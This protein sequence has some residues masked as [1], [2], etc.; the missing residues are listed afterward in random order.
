MPRPILA[1]DT[2]SPEVS[3]AVATLGGGIEQRTFPQRRSGA[4]LIAALEAVL[5]A[6]ALERHDLG[7]IVAVRGPGSFTGLRVGLATA[8]GLSQALGIPATAVSTFQALAWGAAEPGTVLALAHA[9][10]EDWFAQRFRERQ[11]D[12]EPVRLPL[13]RLRELGVERWVAA[14]AEGPHADA[15]AAAGVALAAVGPLA[16][17]LA[18]RAVAAPPPWDAAALSAPLYLAPPPVAP[19]SPPKSVLGPAPPDPSRA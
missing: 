10:H 5:A 16:A 17:V 8:L 6:A 1:I 14:T 4:E 11:P 13:D 19:A 3:V 9:L 12:G 2:A 7:G 18:R 15:A